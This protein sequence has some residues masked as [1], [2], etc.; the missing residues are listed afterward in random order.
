[1]MA[2]NSGEEKLRQEQIREENE[3][4]DLLGIKRKKSSGR[5][6]W[7]LLMFVIGITAS[8]FVPQII[9]SNTKI[10]RTEKA[11]KDIEKKI[12]ATNDGIESYQKKLKDL[13]DP[14]FREKLGRE[15][16]QMVRDGEKIYKLKK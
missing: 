14:F 7:I 12:I 16:L 8:K 3:A 11:I 4:Q 9:R 6:T 13:E 10:Q 1:M 15:K 2:R 5:I